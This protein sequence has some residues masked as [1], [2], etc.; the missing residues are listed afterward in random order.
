MRARQRHFNPGAAGATLTLDARFITGLSDGNAVATWEDRTAS[1]NDATQTNSARRP[2][3][4]TALQGG[5]PVVQ[6]DGA[7][8]LLNAPIL[9]VGASGQETIIAV[10][11]HRILATGYQV[12]ISSGKTDVRCF[13]MTLGNTDKLWVYVNNP[14]NVISVGPSGTTD[15]YIESIAWDGTTRTMNVLGVEQSITNSTSAVPTT[16]QTTTEIGGDEFGSDLDGYIAYIVQLP[17]ANN[18]LRRRIERGAALSFKIAC[19]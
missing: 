15:P 5:Q 2:V 3:Y 14:T 9:T 17:F 16:R 12:I 6:F 19:S 4:K 13:T 1:N 18:P 11:K 7:T 10:Y 8:D